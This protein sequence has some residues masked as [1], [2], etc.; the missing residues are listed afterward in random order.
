[1]S[2]F[3]RNGLALLAVVAAAVWVAPAAGQTAE[4]LATARK[5]FNEALTEES[6]GK[7]DVALEKFLRVKGVKDTAPVR[8]RIASCLE[9]LGRFKEAAQAYDEASAKSD[10]SQQ[11]I[12]NAAR[13]R[14]AI[15][16]KKLAYIT[17]QP[18]EPVP[19]GLVVH[20]DGEAVPSSSYGAPLATN[21][22]KH[23]IDAE[24]DGT[25]RFHSELMLD[26]T[27][28]RSVQIPNQ[29]PTVLPPTPSPTH[30]E[31]PTDRTRTIVGWAGVGVGGA[32]LVTAGILLIAREGDIS[33]I[34]QR[35]P[36]NVCPSSLRSEV[37]TLRSRALVEGPLA[38]TFGLLGAA[39]AGAGAYLLL[40]KPA[41]SQAQT[42]LRILPTPSGLSASFGASF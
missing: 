31:V 24:V 13:E 30:E 12:S 14:A 21:P 17:L 18:S 11:D 4:E 6:Q 19:S 10:K 34:E 22:G 28:T 33:A 36:N 16:R 25:S 39:S 42:S 37:D 35:C 9:A 27:E 1:V 8:Y 40:S 29:S 20:L 15:V 23:S 41:P 3:G 26:E 7:C 5:W 38:L 32:L 2:F